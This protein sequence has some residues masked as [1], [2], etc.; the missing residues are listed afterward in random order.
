MRGLAVFLASELKAHGVAAIAI[1]QGFL[2]SERMLEHFG[3]WS[4]SPPSGTI[5]VLQPRI[6]HRTC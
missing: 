5:D 6:P 4:S 3:V 2:R 1:T